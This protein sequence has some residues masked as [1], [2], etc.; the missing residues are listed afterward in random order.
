MARKLTNSIA[1][2]TFNIILWTSHLVIAQEV[3]GPST[4]SIADTEGPSPGISR[5]KN[6]AEVAEE[7]GNYAM[8][9]NLWRE[10]AKTPDPTGYSS[11]KVAEMLRLQGKFDEAIAIYRQSLTPNSDAAKICFGW[12]RAAEQNAESRSMSA[13]PMI[14]VP[15]QITC[16]E[17][18]IKLQPNDYELHRYLGEL[19]YFRHDVKPAIDAWKNAVRLMPCDADLTTL[20]LT[21]G[22][23]TEALADEGRWKELDIAYTQL[24]QRYPKAKL[25]LMR[26]QGTVLLRHEKFAEAESI[27][28]QIL[29]SEP[30]DSVT[31]FSL[32]QARNKRKF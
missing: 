26:Q 13:N 19:F 24:F 1:L 12:G 23:L 18:A 2:L 6:P 28:T 30:N 15:G 9:E 17:A 5:P 16:T 10:F 20:R 29:Q 14:A 27:F 8:A 31:K 11:Y 32:E 3:C 4:A 25:H 7:S 21:T 22:Y